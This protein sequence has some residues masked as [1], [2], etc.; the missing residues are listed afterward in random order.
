MLKYLTHENAPTKYQYTEDEVTSNYNWKIEKTKA[1]NK[2]NSET[3][4]I[5]IINDIVSGVIREFNYHEHITIDEYDRY[6]K[7]IDNAFKYRTDIIK[8]AKR[9]MNV[10]IL[11]EKVELAKVHMHK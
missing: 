2:S 9:N 8:G 10:F 11:L 6:K 5:Q 7:S 3:R 1:I 4:K